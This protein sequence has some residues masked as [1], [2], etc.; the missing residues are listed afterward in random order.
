MRRTYAGP[1]LG[2]TGEYQDFSVPGSVGFKRYFGE[3]WVRTDSQ[4]NVAFTTFVPV[5]L[6]K[7]T[8]VSATAAQL[9]SNV[10]LST[11][12]FGNVKTV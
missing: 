7:G 9:I 4:G 1:L 10:P 2:W 8:L 12:G 5:A 3:F 6:A 11:T